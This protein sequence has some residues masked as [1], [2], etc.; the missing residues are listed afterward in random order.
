MY[1]E[2]HRLSRAMVVRTEPKIS[3]KKTTNPQNHWA[4]VKENKVCFL[5]SAPHG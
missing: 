2:E 4:R 1:L 5:V 3:A